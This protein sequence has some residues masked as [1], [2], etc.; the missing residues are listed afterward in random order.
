MLT[1]NAASRRN[2][3]S[4][5]NLVNQLAHGAKVYPSR[6]ALIEH[7]REISY[8]SLYAEVFTGADFLRSNS[9]KKGVCVLILEPIGVNLY[10]HLLSVLHAGMSAMIVDPSAGKKVLSN[11]LSLCPP[12][13]FIGSRKAHLLR[14]ANP[15]IRKIRMCFHSEGF[16]PFSRRWRYRANSGS[17]LPCGQNLPSP[18]AIEDDHPA[19]ITF[20]SG[21]TGMPKAACRTHGFLMAQHAALAESLGFK[22]AEVDLITLPVFAIANLASGMT[23]VIANTDL[24]YP[25]RVDSEAIGLQCLEHKITRCAASPAFF[26]KLFQDKN[27]PPFRTIY[28]GGAPVF[29]HLIDAIQRDHPE[30][31]IVT[32]YGSTEAEPISHIAWDEV[33]VDDHEAMKR[34]KGLLV[35]KPVSATKVMI[36]E[37]RQDKIGQIAVTGDH[38]LKGYLNGMGDEETKI[39]SDGEIWHLTGDMGYLDSQNRLWLMG[40]E[41]AVF[42]IGDRVVYPFGIECAVMHHSSVTRCAV[43]KHSGRN[44]LCL[45]LI[46]NSIDRVKIDFSEYDYL[47]FIQ[48]KKIPMDKRHNAKVDYPSLNL[49]LIRIFTR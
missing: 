49:E 7:E 41:S 2:K 36:H 19:L 22:E 45:E 34:G 28:T 43:V 27:L 24:R 10:I 47:E 14:L 4:R 42:E 30:L 39:K 26:N 6:I 23:S 16:L 32:V 44:L 15:S 17:S 18:I 40:R 31:K 25:A 12:D 35:G 1:W 20:T 3:L 9:L 33:S 8:E 5:M 38:V 37:I 29:P 21:S 48:L 13:A 11:C 46:S